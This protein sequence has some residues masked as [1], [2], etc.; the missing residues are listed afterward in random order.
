MK[1]FIPS[2][3]KE[4]DKYYGVRF[5]GKIV[6]HLSTRL[7]LKK[8]LTSSGLKILKDIH[9]KRFRLFEK[10]EA[11]DDPILLRI[12]ANKIDDI[13]YELQDAWGFDRDKKYHSWWFKLPKCK[14]P[15]MDNMD[16]VGTNYNIISG[17]CP[18]HGNIKE[19]QEV[20]V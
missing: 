15:V 7:A 14:C 16:N 18:L 9:R 13:E 8:S 12:L 19:V 5:K 6:F 11:E 10:I 17:N 3:K 20:S 2:T 4:L 1:A